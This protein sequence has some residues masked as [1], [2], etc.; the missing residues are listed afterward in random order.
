MIEGGARRVGLTDAQEVRMSSSVLSRRC[1]VGISLGA[2]LALPSLG[3]EGKKR[4][5]VKWGEWESWFDGKTMKGW[6][7]TEYAAGGDVKVEDGGIHIAMG[8]ELSGFSRVGDVPREGYELE[9]E[10]MRKSGAD[11]P[12]GLTFPVGKECVTFVVGGWGGGVVGLSSINDQD[13]SGNETTKFEPI[14]DNV[15]YAVKVRVLPD[16]IAGYL[17]GKEMFS[18]DPRG[19]KLS[20][21]RGEIELCMP[22][23]IATFRTESVVRS[24]RVRRVAK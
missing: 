1:F 12:C 17:N 4:A 22:V 13:A 6:K 5:E 14:K 2:V 10:V 11:F 23:G 18:F 20:M 19:K 15:W 16:E 9:L 7:Q 21:R 24:V 8:E 3:A